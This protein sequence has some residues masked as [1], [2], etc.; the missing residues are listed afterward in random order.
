MAEERTTAVVQRDLDELAVDAPV[1]PV[2]RALLDRAVRRQH[3]LRATL[4]YRSDPRPTR[5]PLRLGRRNFFV[6]LLASV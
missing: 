6:P 4:L 5:P 1:E 2:V 3:R